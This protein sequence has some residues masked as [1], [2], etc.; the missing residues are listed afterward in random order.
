MN[1]ATELFLSAFGLIMAIVIVSEVV[2]KSL[3]AFKQ[4]EEQ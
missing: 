1:F 4:G 2:A 3:G